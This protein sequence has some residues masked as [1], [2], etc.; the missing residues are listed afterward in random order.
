MFLGVAVDVIIKDR[1]SSIY[2][3]RFCLDEGDVETK[4]DACVD[5]CVKGCSFLCF[6]G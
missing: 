5:R 1:L 2:L 3:V 6:S 4:V